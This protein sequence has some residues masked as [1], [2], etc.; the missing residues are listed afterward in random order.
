MELIKRWRIITERG[1]FVVS[2][3]RRDSADRDTVYAEWHAVGSGEMTR[4]FL[5]EPKDGL[6]RIRVRATSVMIECLSD[7]IAHAGAI[8]GI[9]LMRG[10]EQGD[11]NGEQDGKA[12]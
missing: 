1:E 8:R 7:I 6:P 3:R 5:D 10:D 2:I 11:Q 9:E 12:E 4:L